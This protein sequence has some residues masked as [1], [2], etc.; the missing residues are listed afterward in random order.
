MV[1]QVGI[2]AHVNT[3]TFT[4]MSGGIGVPGLELGTALVV[5]LIL[6]ECVARRKSGSTEYSVNGI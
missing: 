2:T 5:L 4:S 3:N 6:S 1:V